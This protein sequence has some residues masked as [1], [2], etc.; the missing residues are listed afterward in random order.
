MPARG[1]RVKSQMF[2]TQEVQYQPRA[3]AERITR[4]EYGFYRMQTYKNYDCPFTLSQLNYPL[5]FKLNINF[6]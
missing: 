1:F 4:Y 3:Y 5:R 2:L 6:D